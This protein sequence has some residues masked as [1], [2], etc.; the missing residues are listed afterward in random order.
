MVIKRDYANFARLSSVFIEFNSQ[1]T[2]QVAY[3]TLMHN[4]PLHMAP[5]YIG[6][7]PDEVVWSNM[8]LF[9][10]ERLTKFA[11]TTAFIVAL[12]IFWSIPVA[13]VGA[14]SNIQFLTN[15]VKFLSFINDIPEVILGVVTGLLPA[16]MLAVLMALLPI[17]LR[18]K[19]AGMCIEIEY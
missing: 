13:V 16:V 5:R 8:R 3:Q 15:K 1:S 11:T 10:W 12:V 14:I 18:C 17:V 4:K 9:W 7:T 6:V 19:L 2:A